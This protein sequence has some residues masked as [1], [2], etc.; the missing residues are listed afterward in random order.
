MINSITKKKPKRVKQHTT[1]LNSQCIIFPDK[2]KLTSEGNNVY[3]LCEWA[4]H[5]KKVSYNFN[6][7][8]ILFRMLQIY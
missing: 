8:Q 6:N 1:E 7:T 5:R 4:I 2:N 3:E